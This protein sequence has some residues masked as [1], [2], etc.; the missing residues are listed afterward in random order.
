MCDLVTLTTPTSPERPPLRGL[1]LVGSPGG[2]VIVSLP[3]AL[4]CRGPAGVMRWALVERIKIG[5]P[6]R[7]SLAFAS[8][9]AFFIHRA[10]VVAA[11][12]VVGGP[13]AAAKTAAAPVEEDD[14]LDRIRGSGDARPQPRL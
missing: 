14:E 6:S 7:I 3:L 2:L 1:D 9:A 8:S 10:I 12:D 11:I 5:L 13:P 4:R